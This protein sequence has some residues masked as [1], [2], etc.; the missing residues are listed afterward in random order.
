MTAFDA[1]RAGGRRPSAARSKFL[2]RFVNAGSPGLLH[3]R[4]NGA[5]GLDTSSQSQSHRL[6]RMPRFIVE[7]QVMSKIAC[8]PAIMTTR[9]PA[10]LLVTDPYGTKND[11]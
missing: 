3:L 2:R 6:L 9:S 1:E 8:A 7:A 5:N 4:H 11:T 10:R